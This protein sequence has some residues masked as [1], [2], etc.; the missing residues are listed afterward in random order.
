MPVGD[1]GGAM[2]WDF[3]ATG[4]QFSLAINELGFWHT[5][6]EA[7]HYCRPS[8]G[9]V[10]FLPRIQTIKRASW[11]LYPSGALPLNVDLLGKGLHEY[12][13]ANPRNTC[14]MISFHDGNPGLLSFNIL[15]S[16]HAS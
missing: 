1:K 13:E 9:D 2:S 6:G 10:S 16:K 8:G 12:A 15:A 4:T 7:W 11:S 14:A 5:Y 3:G